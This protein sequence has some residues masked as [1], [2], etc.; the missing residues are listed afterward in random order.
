MTPQ[1]LSD[2]LALFADD[3]VELTALHV[4]ERVVVACPPSSFR[5]PFESAKRALN[6][7]KRRGYLSVRRSKVNVYRFVDERPRLPHGWLYEERRTGDGANQRVWTMILSPIYGARG[8]IGFVYEPETK[9]ARPFSDVPKQHADRIAT[10]LRALTK[11]AL[12][13]AANELRNLTLAPHSR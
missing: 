10:G 6:E 9:S 3:K 5:L 8:P 13:A 12:E 2:V 7:L 1:I 4:S 11:E